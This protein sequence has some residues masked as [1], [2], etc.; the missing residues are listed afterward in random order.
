MYKRQDELPVET[1]DEATEMM[2]EDTTSSLDPSALL[3]LEL[4]STDA[5]GINDNLLQ[6]IGVSTFGLQNSED[7]NQRT[8]QLLAAI[9]VIQHNAINPTQFLDNDAGT[10]FQRIDVEF[11]IDDKRVGISNSNF[12]NALKQIDSD[13]Q[14]AEEE[15]ALQIKISNEA[16]FGL[17][18][19][20]TAGIVAWVLRGGALLAS[21]MAATPIWAS[22]DPVR[23][24]SGQDEE[25]A[26][27][28]SEVE[29]M[30]E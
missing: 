19:S 15:R 22:I 20:A 23:V 13:L 28:A 9:E 2:E 17:S 26:K 12:I 24:F 11:L 25:K 16:L 29:K 8:L 30:F 6:E 21:V 3:G 7:Q 10:Q 18:I 14:D 1:L 27:E 5:S 4:P